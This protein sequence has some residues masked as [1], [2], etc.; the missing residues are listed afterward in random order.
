M[1]TFYAKKIL[2]RCV[3][4]GYT[5][6]PHATL[7]AD[8]DRWSRPEKVSD[9]CAEAQHLELYGTKGC[10]MPSTAIVDVAIG[11][12]FVYLFFSL[13]CSVVNEGIAAVLSLRAKN[14]VAGITS[15]FSGSKTADG[16]QFVQAI[17]E[18]GLVRG[19]FKDPPA[20][21]AGAAASIEAELSKAAQK[22][23][24]VTLPSYIPSATFATAL[25]DTI[26]PPTTAP[27]TLDDVRKAIAALPDNPAKEALMSL[28][29]STQSELSEFQQKVENWYNDS[30]ER[31]AGW[32]KRNTQKFL[33]VIALAVTV[34]LN[35]DTLHIALTLWNNPVARQATVDL[36]QSYVKDQKNLP[37]NNQG[38]MA[39]AKSLSALGESLPIPFGWSS[40]K[41]DASQ[42]AAP[43]E[44][45][46]NP[47]LNGFEM[48]I[49]WLITTLALSLGAPFWFDVLS[50]FMVVRSTIKPQ[51]KS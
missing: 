2:S 47:R 20:A 10:A 15:L 48:L 46:G 41:P 35:V 45:V 29:A 26:A 17:Y 21:A 9:L 1:S 27:R 34:A 7:L 49:G 14:L 50:K 18:H 28:I 36:A 39:Q 38:L 33:L 30:M 23:K 42:P 16:T 4:L 24:Q 22:L 51:D 37:A 3:V 5:F 6:R 44:P 12:V 19:L 8:R 11:I 32:Y 31:A 25:I 40:K 43:P 13:I